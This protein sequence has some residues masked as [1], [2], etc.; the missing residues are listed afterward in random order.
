MKTIEVVLPG[1]LTTVQDLGREGFGSLGISPSGA[2]DAISLRLGNILVGNPQNTA[3]LEM[4]LLG[5]EFRFSEDCV[6]AVTGSDFGA[7]LEGA[8]IS[9]W[10][11]VQV[12]SGQTLR[13]GQTRSGAR[14]YLCV[15]GG[16]L[17]KPFL[18][19]LNIRGGSSL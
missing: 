3:A 5:G 8:P 4:T 17:V 14:C 10:T 1:L 6:T 19:F 13:L 16:I 15:Q 18:A 7:T 2:A 11:A 9:L 12:R